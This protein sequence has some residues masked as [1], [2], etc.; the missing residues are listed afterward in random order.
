M[1]GESTDH[2]RA[3][4][5]AAALVVRVVAALCLLTVPVAAQDFTGTWYGKIEGPAAN[6]YRKLVVATVGSNLSCAFVQIAA[7]S[8]ADSTCSIEGGALLLVTAT[9][10]RVRL[11]VT[12]D[13]LDGTTTAASTGKSFHI[14]MAHNP[15]Q[16]GIPSNV[17]VSSNYT[18]GMAP[19]APA[20][21]AQ[22]PIGWRAFRTLLS[23][24]HKLCGDEP[25]PD[26]D[27]EIR[28]K[29]LT[30]TPTGGQRTA[31]DGNTYLDLSGLKSDGSGRLSGK[32]KSNVVW[33]FDFDPGHGRRVIIV[34]SEQSECAYKLT[35]R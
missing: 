18:F 11:V 12:G 8:G 26:Y 35:P 1:P 21:S 29:W 13:A 33:Y 27:I 10:N 7:T 15:A 25:F 14:R 5:G 6:P 34:R 9:H 4:R 32:S 23:G 2:T 24:T 3:S 20:I 30:G 17:P 16:A 31:I 28:G 22:G 19:Q